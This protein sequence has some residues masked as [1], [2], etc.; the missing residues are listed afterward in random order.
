MRTKTHG[1]FSLFMKSGEPRKGQGGG[2]VLED[3]P[4]ADVAASVFYRKKTQ[5]LC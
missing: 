3:Q 5:V 1:V 4:L 2:G